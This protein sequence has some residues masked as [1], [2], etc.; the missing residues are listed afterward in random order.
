VPATTY[1]GT[2]T[3]LRGL[4]AFAES[5]RDVLFGRDGEREDLA[6]LVSAEGFR[7]GLVYGE[8]GV[9]K[10][11][12]LRAGVV[13][14]LRDHGVV[15]L[16]CDDIFRPEESFARAMGQATGT[17]RGATEQPVQFL[18]RIL[19]DAH[20]QI[21]LFIL[22]EADV[23]LSSSRGAAAPGA[24]GSVGSADDR[25]VSE[26]GELFARVVARSAGRARFLFAC[27]SERL[28]V[29]GALERRTG[30]LFPP[31][32]R[33]ELARFQPDQA[34]HV[35]ER[36]LALA[37]AS[38]DPALANALAAGLAQ[39]GAILPADLQIA[40][41]AVVQLGI[42]SPA[43]LEKLGGPRELEAEWLRRAAAATGDERAALRLLAELGRAPG[44]HGPCP[45]QP[46]T[47]AASRASVDVDFARRALAVLQDKGVTRSVPV[48][49]D[50]PPLHTLAHEIMAPRVREVAAPARA[51]ARRAFE[52]LGSKAGKRR[53]LGLREWYE[54]WREG[55]S[56]STAAER[57]VVE[58]TRRFA[59][60]AIAV[61]IG[62]PIALLLLI[63]FSLAGRYYL[64]A[65]GPGSTG[66]VVVR[67]GRAGLSAFNWLPGGFGDVV[68]DTGFTR[69]MIAPDQWQAITD[70]EIGGD[71]DD[72]G[73]SR[74][75]FGALRPSL[76]GL[77]EYAATGSETALDG[78]VKGAT[79]PDDM[80]A[81][82]TG[83]QPIARGLPQEI[84]LVESSLADPSPAVQSAAL[85]LAA[86]AERRRPGTYRATLARALASP[87]GDLRRLAVGAVR[88]LAGDTGQA[89][90]KEA[91]ALGP[92]PATRRELG[93]LLAADAGTAAPS[94][95][96]ALAMLA[97]P[98]GKN[99][100]PEARERARSLLRRAFAGAAA[101]AAAA[102]GRLVADESAPPDD[103]V[104]AIDLL[105]ELAP[106]ASYGDLVE[107]AKQ[108]RDS[109]TE[110]VRA[111]A[112]PLYARVA[113]QEAAG[114]L[115]LMLE[116]QA[117]SSAM[118]VAMA[119][120]WGEVAARNKGKAAQAALEK[121]I[122]DASPKVRAAAA[123]AY[124]SVGRIA[125]STLAKMVKG[126]RYEVALGAAQGLARSAEAGGSTSAAVSGINQLWKQKGRPRRDAARIFAG[127]ARSKPGAVSDQ[128]AGASRSTDDPALHPIGVE[129]LCNAM[130]AGERGAIAELGRTVK[131]GSPE[132]RRLTLQ[133]LAD[134]PK[135]LSSASR[136]ALDLSS[137]PDRQNRAEAARMVAALTAGGK[138]KA[139]VG[140]AL[141]RLAKDEDRE[142][143]I[144][145]IRA[146]AALGDGAPRQAVE[147]LPRAYDGADETERLVI[148]EAARQ[149]GAGEL[150]RIGVSDPSPL[151]RVAALDTALATRTEVAAIMQ[152]ALS[153][154]DTAVR[155]AA[156]ARLAAGAPGLSVDDAER[157]LVLA[158]RDRDEALSVLALAAL[159]RVAQPE[160][161]AERLRRLLASPSERERARAAQAARGL[162]E[163]DPKAAIALLEPLYA[164]PS[165]DVRA[166]MMRSLA[167]AYAASRKPAELGAMLAESETEPTRRLVVVAAF[168]VLAVNPATRDAALADLEKAVAGGPPFAKLVGRLGL[169]LISSSADGL[170]FLTEL[171][172]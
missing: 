171:V 20:G 77:I 73:F 142:V 170:T 110:A 22:D 137:D 131:G 124:G 7:A 6:R 60:I 107:P 143:R 130:V 41:L 17:M 152:S 119:L 172:P 3:P 153:D 158:V 103:R 75:A 90:I 55:L 101:D 112:L 122:T 62:L 30:S 97:Q 37:G 145:A 85:A 157:A 76:R 48:A 51:A 135:Y 31:S 33:Y 50:G 11:S 133:C 14:H 59:R 10:T 21:F 154:P 167:A 125:Q 111:A 2:V 163:R 38:A 159:A 69:P 58:R 26:L 84:A 23:A 42:S 150:A 54:I 66:R 63:W 161:V 160:Q 126:E 118:K 19:A 1:P 16:M 106:P 15:A 120:A 27:A 105:R 4:N 80:A 98:S 96:S 43:S 88:G 165:R 141:A 40:A 149:I 65:V 114:D 139:E 102:C 8:S 148:L 81:L 46:V 12:L 72:G 34:A 91:L 53:R 169:G 64:D 134:N 128:L 74:Q 94:A 162:A 39:D 136:L 67:E 70:H 117:L 83:L 93:A 115:A 5:E 95:S 168:V 87:S 13:P 144:I 129:G 100:P 68:A 113:P 78:L 123:E 140:E 151:V 86:A 89:L 82:L 49:G 25:V 99:A 32:T 79:T 109:K 164:D 71:L 9:G 28:H 166:A 116:N 24:V 132:V 52:L 45:P 36:T 35:L 156:V 61:A 147:S 108:A 47:T 155:R 121:L 138:V 18:A 57:Q 104:F 56:P 44:S 92:D 146:L 29:F 127:L